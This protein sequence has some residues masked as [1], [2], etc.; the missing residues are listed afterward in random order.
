ME[1][2]VSIV[3]HGYPVNDPIMYGGVNLL[4]HVSGTCSENELNQ[5]MALEP[6]LNIKDNLGRTA[7]HF[8]CRAGNVATFKV[9]A[10]FDDTEVDGVTNAG[11][12]PLMMAIESGNI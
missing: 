6:G 8:A 11:V 12:T 3:K 2:V 1:P 9:L 4:M 7:L 5:I 10:N